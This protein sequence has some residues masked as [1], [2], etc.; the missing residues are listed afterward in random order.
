MNETIAKEYGIMPF[1]R[2]V[3]NGAFFGSNVF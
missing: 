2:L 3:A 1:G